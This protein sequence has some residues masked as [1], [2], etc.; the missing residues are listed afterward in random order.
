V[1]LC[2]TEK[3]G[4]GYECILDEDTE[5]NPQCVERCD[6][7]SSENCVSANSEVYKCKYEGSSCLQ[8]YSED[9]E[10]IRDEKSCRA[11]KNDKEENGVVKY[12]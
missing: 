1:T 7:R 9:C 4:G 10:E 11:I 6:V 12:K 3:Q 5:N 2:E 8:V